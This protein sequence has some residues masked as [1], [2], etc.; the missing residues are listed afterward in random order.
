MPN[1]YFT[2]P[3]I[4][5]ALQVQTGIDD[6]QW[7]YNINTQTY[8]T[9]GGEVVQILSAFTD[10]ISLTGTTRAYW[11]VEQ[12]YN[13]FLSYMQIATQGQPGNSENY[14]QEPVTMVYKERGWNWKI[15]PLSLPGFRYGREVVAPTW[16]LQAVVKEESDATKS[17]NLEAARQGIEK[18][19]PGIGFVEDNPFS[20]PFADKGAKEA[21]E[22]MHEFYGDAADYFSSLI[23]KYM[24]GDYESLLG[25]IG[26]KPAFLDG[27]AGK[28][29]G[30][31]QER[32]NE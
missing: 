32:P 4:E 19:T 9:Y 15:H 6:I 28:D 27:R 30:G 5:S 31:R 16:S 7:G 22:S 18:V 10:N 8:P 17:L 25:E 29:N 2:H 14:N 12:I 26:S 23:P 20:D 13:W 1:I 11:K 3:K 21:K 24:E